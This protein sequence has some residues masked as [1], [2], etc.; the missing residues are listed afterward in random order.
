MIFLEKKSL[1]QMPPGSLESIISVLSQKQGTASPNIPLLMGVLGVWVSES[2][3]VLAG[4][5]RSRGDGWYQTH[6]TNPTM[7][8]CFLEKRQDL[9]QEHHRPTQLGQRWGAH[10]FSW[11]LLRFRVEI[12]AQPPRPLPT[13]CRGLRRGSCSWVCPVA[14]LP[15]LAQPGTAL[16]TARGRLRCKLQPDEF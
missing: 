11:H 14:L 4:G 1:S 8:C 16:I 9:G 10:S 13:G 12:W 15:R 6:H 3:D 5:W 7:F 2:R